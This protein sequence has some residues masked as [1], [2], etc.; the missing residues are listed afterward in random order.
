MKLY[1][2]QLLFLALF[3]LPPF[4]FL[5]FFGDSSNYFVIP[6]FITAKTILRI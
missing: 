1:S 6:A 5:T 2:F 3:F 4:F